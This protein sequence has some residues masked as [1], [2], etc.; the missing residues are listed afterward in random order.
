MVRCHAGI[1]HLAMNYMH[2]SH[3]RTATSHRPQTASF[4]TRNQQSALPT[5]E[6]SRRQVGRARDTCTPRTDADSSREARRPTRGKLPGAKIG[7]NDLQLRGLPSRVTARVVGCAG[8]MRYPDGGG[9]AAAERGRREQVRLAR[10]ARS[11]WTSAR[12][13]SGMRT[14]LDAGADR[15]PGVAAVRGGAH[16]G[17]DGRA[18]AP[19]RP[20]ISAAIG[21][22]GQSETPRL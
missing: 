6:S 1:K 14:V 11:C 7:A 5:P 19:D 8:G 18:A 10:R 21:R 9:L 3:L 20:V 22:T 4:R 17:R 12:R 16:A 13:W 2:V 15:G